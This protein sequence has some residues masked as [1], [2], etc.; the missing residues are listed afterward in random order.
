MKFAKTSEYEVVD[1]KI[2]YRYFA[3]DWFLKHTFT[4]YYYYLKIALVI[5]LDGSHKYMINDNEAPI[6]TFKT[7][8]EGVRE[9]QNK[10]ILGYTMN[11]LTW[12]VKKG[13]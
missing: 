12:S 1:L 13:V 6:M 3:Q 2:T 9:K 5:F 7:L 10:T 11:K 4:A 8:T